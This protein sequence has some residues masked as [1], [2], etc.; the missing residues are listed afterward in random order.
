MAD[1]DQG[2]GGNPPNMGPT[3]ENVTS[4]QRL[5]DTFAEMRNTLQ[6]ISKLFQKSLQR[7]IENLDSV[8]QKVVTK[9]GK[10]L[11]KE[12]SDS[13]KQTQKLEAMTESMAKKLNNEA[14]VESAIEAVK[15]RQLRVDNIMADIKLQGVQLTEQQREY[16]EDI[17]YQLNTQLSILNKQLERVKDIEKVGKRFRNVL[18]GLNKVP[19]IGQ[20]INT[21]KVLKKMNE[22]AEKGASKWKVIGVGIRETFASI[23]TNLI[24]GG[25]LSILKFVVKAVMEVNKM[26]FEL[27]KNLGVS[28]EEGAKL[29]AQF[30]SIANSSSNAGLQAKDIS[31]SYQEISQAFGFLAPSNREFSET[32][33]LIQKRIGASA[34]SMAAL[35]SYGAM[36]GQ[37]LMQ[38]YGTL[39]RSRQ[40][41]GARNKLNLSLRQIMDGIAKVSATVVINFR[42]SVEALGNAVIRAT[43]LGTTL[44]TVNKQAEGLVEF[45]DSIEK[46]LQ[47][48]IITGRDI[49]LTRARELALAG[50]T[51]ELMEELNRQQVDYDTF[52]NQTVF[53]RRAE[54]E[55]L[56]LTS[57]ELSSILLK[58]KQAKQLGAEEGQ[59]LVE[60]YNILRQRGKS[61]ADII[62]MLGDKQ[63]AADLEKASRAEQFEKIMERLKTTL[64]TMLEGPVGGLIDKF[65]AFVNDGKKMEY[66]G[67]TLKT[68]FSTI[69]NIIKNFPIILSSAIEVLKGIVSLSIA[70]ATANAVGAMIAIPGIGPL[71]GIAAGY[72]V[73]NWLSGLVSG[74]GASMT[75]PASM[76]GTPAPMKEPVNQPAASAATTSA[77][78]QETAYQK[79]NL[80]FNV[81]AQIGTERLG[82]AVRA[83][84]SEDLGS[85]M[86]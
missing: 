40:I 6:D 2:G 34:E 43:K 66:I 62:A 8:T 26:G 3:Q 45:E 22:E 75:S 16:H 1:G 73:Y 20:L 59:S 56:H 17:S 83:S 54:A 10:D 30:I 46:E 28:V 68:I 65:A 15:Q 12:L 51:Q 41:E 25:I 71:A 58:Q 18:E 81:V 14:S 37:S 76:T 67:N 11:E 9:L 86:A 35:A 39:N 79:P 49:N 31:K 36:N 85:V 80:N 69:N 42:G 33:A 74:I 64:G 29:N 70:A 61:E 4:T 78:G 77:A 7:D 72:T 38:A 53:E 44:D 50:K 84:V 21:S 82:P 60:R 52:I 13:V 24:F 55:M 27:A 47:A 48:Q 5:K 57:E 63:A 23:G 19:F 32:A